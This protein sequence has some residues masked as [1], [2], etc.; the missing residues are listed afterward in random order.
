M[1]R[2]GSVCALVVLWASTCWATYT[3]QYETYRQYSSDAND[4]LYQ[5]VVVDGTTTGDCYYNC[6]CGQYGCQQCTIP[7]CPAL[8]TPSV[9]NVLGG[10]GGTSSG[11]TYGM[12]NYISYQTT[13]SI[14]AISGQ[15]Y[16]STGE[17]L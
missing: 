13:V 12:F 15:D 14:A 11:S 10:V 4:N 9:N 2:A 8:H 17:G 5:T 6:N 1:K 7:N 3:P 16:D